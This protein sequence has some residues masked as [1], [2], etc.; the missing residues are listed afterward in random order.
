MPSEVLN[1]AVSVFGPAGLG[2]TLT[3]R[4][5]LSARFDESTGHIAIEAS[6]LPDGDTEVTI[7]TM[8]L[9]NEVVD[10]ISR[11]PRRSLLYS[12]THWLQQRLARS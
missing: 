2:M 12:L 6:R 10:F 11:L 4:D 5:L 3:E 8:H 9:D 7:E 1:R